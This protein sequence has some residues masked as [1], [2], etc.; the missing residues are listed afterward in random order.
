MQKAPGFRQGVF[1][2]SIA[3]VGAAAG[4]CLRERC[5]C[6]GETSEVLAFEKT[7]PAL[8]KPGQRV[9][10]TV[11]LEQMEQVLRVP[12]GALFERDGR[13]VLYRWQGRGFAPVAV[14]VGHGSASWVVVESGLREGDRVALRDP[15]V[16]KPLESPAVAPA[17]PARP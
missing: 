6:Y 3:A 5:V 4:V 9:R 7:D 17:G 12:R 10:A 2:T 1:V 13:R 11:R 14:A 8:M 16:A 15:T